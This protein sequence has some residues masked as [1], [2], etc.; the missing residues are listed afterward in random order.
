[1]TVR[2]SIMRWLSRGETVEDSEEPIELTVVPLA[3]GP[4]TVETLRARGF[5]ASGAP[6]F[7]VITDV[8]SNYRIL[9]LRK[10]F[11]AATSC[12][13]EFAG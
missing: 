3:V 7:S 5:H 1:M 13:D 8:G 6:A 10:E 11:T 2:D 12:L 4:I 9:V